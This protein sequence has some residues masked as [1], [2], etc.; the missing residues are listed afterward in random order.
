M[1]VRIYELYESLLNFSDNPYWF[2]CSFNT[3]VLPNIGEKIECPGNTWN[4]YS[5]IDRK[6]KVSNDKL[7]CDLQVK[8]YK[9]DEL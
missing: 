3:D 9:V 6:F 8:K 1:Y 2:I 7:E 4:T 5:I